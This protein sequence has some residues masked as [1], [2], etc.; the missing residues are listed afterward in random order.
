M[1]NGPTIAPNLYVAWMSHNSRCDVLYSSSGNGQDWA[2]RQ[3]TCTNAAYGVCITKFRQKLWIAEPDYHPADNGTNLISSVDGQSWVHEARYGY[4]VGATPALA[5]FNDK[6]YMAYIRGPWLWFL[7]VYDNVQHWGIQQSIVTDI[8]Y[9]LGIATFGLA[10]VNGRLLLAYLDP[11]GRV[12]IKTMQTTE[13]W[14]AAAE[15]TAAFRIDP[16]LTIQG[17]RIFPVDNQTVA[18]ALLYNDGSVN[19][20]DI[21]VDSA[22][23]STVGQCYHQ[24]L[25]SRSTPGITYFNSRYWLSFTSANDAQN[26]MLY[27]FNIGQPPQVQI[28]G[29]GNAANGDTAIIGINYQTGTVTPKFMVLT[30]M[31]APPGVKSDVPGGTRSNVTYSTGSSAGALHSVSQSFTVGV[32]AGVSAGVPNSDQ[33]G[34]NWSASLSASQE[35]SVKI[36][37]TASNSLT[38]NGSNTIDG[39]DHDLDTFV[40]WIN[41]RLTVSIDNLG[42]VSWVPAPYLDPQTGTTVIATAQMSVAALKQSI[43]LYD[44]IASGQGNQQKLRNELQRVNPNQLTLGECEGLLAL[45]PL[46]NGDAP[47]APRFIPADPAG[48]GYSYDGGS[49]TVQQSSLSITVESQQSQTT[50]VSETYSVSATAQEDFLRETLGA[51]LSLSNSVTNQET[52]IS[53]QS[54]AYTIYPPSA[55]YDGPEE[56]YVYWDRVYGTFAF[57]FTAPPQH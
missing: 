44:Q 16:S 2:G 17:L 7:S 41:P 50:S 9:Q 57:S 3:T 13:E 52:S 12:W 46:L 5:P 29:D 33:I 4:S 27:G 42:N 1:A 24:G 18:I 34:A 53:T 48:I 32:S 19:T 47:V 36:T 54:A 56:L 55:Q 15:Y 37:K 23:I 45:N 25:G 31:Y 8:A 26:L 30:L 38:Q 22:G 21:T 20:A 51:S 39:L 35:S 43:G 11:S 14:G 6:L 28:I 10:S 49:D 40:L